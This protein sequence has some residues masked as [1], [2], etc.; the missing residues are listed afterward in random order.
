MSFRHVVLLCTAALISQFALAT[1]PPPAHGAP[2]TSRPDKA[3][4]SAATAQ[5]IGLVEAVVDFCSK[6][7]PKDKGQIERKAKELLPKMSEDSLEAVRHRA[8]YHSAYGLI[9]N[10]LQG[11][12][13]SDA[14]RNCAAVR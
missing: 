10:V 11:L 6:A 2:L 8:E 4:I 14:V 3:R 5:Q 12:S 9:Q 1:P 7:D 13:K